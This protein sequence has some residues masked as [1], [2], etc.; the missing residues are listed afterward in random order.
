MYNIPL[1]Q[2]V[3]RMDRSVFVSTQFLKEISRIAFPRP[4]LHLT[5]AML[6]L[7]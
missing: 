7:S 1:N 2:R 6:K 5:L 4:R 3:G